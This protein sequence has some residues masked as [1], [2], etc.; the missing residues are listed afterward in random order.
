LKDLIRF[1][2]IQEELVVGLNPVAYQAL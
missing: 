2:Q 1:L